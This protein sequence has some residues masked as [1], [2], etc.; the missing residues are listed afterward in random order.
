M[1]R[2]KHT[3]AALPSPFPQGAGL[4][5]LGD[6]DREAIVRAFFPRVHGETLRGLL[7]RYPHPLELE[8]FCMQPKFARD[9]PDGDLELS[10]DELSQL[11]EGLRGIY[12][13]IWDQLPEPV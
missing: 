5:D 10:A 11:P 9:F 13:V 8:L 4:A 2:I 6:A 12:D 1:I 7:N 3:D